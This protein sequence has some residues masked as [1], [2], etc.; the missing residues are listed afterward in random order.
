MH[1]SRANGRTQNGWRSA[2]ACQARDHANQSADDHGESWLMYL[3]CH[4]LALGSVC[5][6]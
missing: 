2:G 5:D 4:L 6:L 3:D 1:G